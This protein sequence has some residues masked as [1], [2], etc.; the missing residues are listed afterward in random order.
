MS[1]EQNAR[2]SETNHPYGAV[3][4]VLE[5]ENAHRPNG[6][7]YLPKQ[8][9]GHENEAGEQ[10]RP[11][12]VAPGDP[13][14]QGQSPAVLAAPPL[15]DGMHTSGST[16]RGKALARRPKQPLK[17]VYVEH[18]G[19]PVEDAEVSEETTVSLTIDIQRQAELVCAAFL[20]HSFPHCR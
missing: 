17:R 15:S 3:H 12:A 9:F 7:H 5:T 18:E 2:V 14:D 6:R 4:E 19:P 11:A 8:M 16:R 1:G 20:A 13:S 10:P